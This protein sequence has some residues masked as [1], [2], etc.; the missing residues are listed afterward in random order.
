MQNNLDL[1]LCTLKLEWVL[2]NLRNEKSNSMKK[3]FLFAIINFIMLSYA[4]AT[5]RQ[6]ILIRHTD[7]LAQHHTGPALSAKG[8]VR[9]LKFSFYFL[10]YFGEP[11]FVIAGKP[12]GKNASIRELQTIGPLVNILAERHPD[13]G[14]SILHPYTHE[15]YEELTKYILNDTKFNN[16]LIL[17]CWRHTKI[18]ELA[19]ELGV[20]D[21]LKPWADDDYDSVYILD[22][23]KSGKINKFTILN[24]QYPMQNQVTWDNVYQHVQYL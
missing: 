11:D 12:K 6:I 5:P 19:K 15:E 7:K 17:I 14:F 24:N 18:I 22:Y 21:K 9:A 10:N 20:K 2:S 16:K 8:Y 1:L 23:G 3:I 13:T 4:C